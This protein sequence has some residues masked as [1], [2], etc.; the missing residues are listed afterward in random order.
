MWDISFG[1]SERKGEK[2]TTRCMSEGGLS[3]PSRPRLPVVVVI[4][5]ANAVELLV[6]V[7][8][9]VGWTLVVLAVVLDQDERRLGGRKGG[10][11]L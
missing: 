3:F 2:R 6:C 8:G 9:K 7:A 1:G 10:N 4:I 11:A 5:V